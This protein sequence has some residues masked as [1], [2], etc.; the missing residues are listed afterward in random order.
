MRRR[1]IS[2]AILA[3]ATGSVLLSQRTEAQTCTAP[4]YPQTYAEQHAAPPVTPTNTAYPEGNA[5]RYMTVAQSTDV[6]AGT[7]TQ[8]VTVPLRTAISVGVPVFLPNGYYLIT[9]SIN[10]TG[11]K[12]FELYGNPYKSQLINKAAP[13]TPTLILTDCLYFVVSGIVLGGR[14]GFPNQ[15]LLINTAGGTTHTAFGVFNDVCIQSNGIGIELQKCNTIRFN[16][17]SY[18]PSNG[19]G[20]ILNTCDAGTRKYAAFADGTI[21]GNFS[22]EVTFDAC[23]LTGVDNTISGYSSV[24]IAAPTLGNSQVVRLIDCELEGTPVFLGKIFNPEIAGC[25]LDRSAVTLNNC[26]YGSL[27]NSFNPHTV[28]LVG[29]VNIAVEH[30]AQGNVGDTLTID[31]TSTNCAVINCSLVSFADNGAHTTLL[32]WNLQGTVQKDKLNL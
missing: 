16:R 26:R 20:G 30:L 18:W 27:K 11:I 7:L 12:Q 24:S 3:S 22:N 29:C 32:N 9:G 31:N 21:A 10:P 23:N 19:I 25:Y 17:V 4:C 28:S 6:V 1:D 14:A 15:G 13:N 8:D 2:K 5:F